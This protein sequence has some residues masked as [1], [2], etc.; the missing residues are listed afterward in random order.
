MRKSQI[1]SHNIQNSGIYIELKQYS[2][3]SLNLKKSK[4][5]TMAIRL[6]FHGNE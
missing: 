1:H 6:L 4:A 2:P 5:K 3:S